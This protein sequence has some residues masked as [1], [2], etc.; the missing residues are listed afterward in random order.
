MTTTPRDPK[1]QEVVSRLAS[2]DQ[3]AGELIQELPDQLVIH[4]GKVFQSPKLLAI[5]LQ[6]VVSKTEPADLAHRYKI[7]LKWVL[8]YRDLCLRA[9]RRKEVELWTK[10]STPPKPVARSRHA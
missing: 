10:P 8:K 3:S 4:L 9:L 7:P 1:A 2:V 5:A 6:A